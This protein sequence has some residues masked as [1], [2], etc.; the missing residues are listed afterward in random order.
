MITI[1]KKAKNGSLRIWW[2]PQIPGKSFFVPVE[3]ISEAKK[4]L[5]VLADYD[6]WQLE[7]NI[8][9]DFS[10]AGGLSVFNDGEWL[11]W[12]DEDGN[13]IDDIEPASQNEGQ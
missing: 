5:C 4:I 11:D 12:E 8:K 1:D 10:N 3:N 6:I 13:G 7:N 2:I 9:P